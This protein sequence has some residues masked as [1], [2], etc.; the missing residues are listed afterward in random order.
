M[1]GGGDGGRRFVRGGGDRG[2][3]SGDWSRSKGI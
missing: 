2:V 1:R 3:G